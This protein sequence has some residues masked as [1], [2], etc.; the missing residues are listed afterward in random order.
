[1]RK[2]LSAVA[3]A[4]VVVAGCGSPGANNVAACNKF[5]AALKCGSFDYTANYMCSSYENTTCDI[6]AYFD[7]LTPKYSCV[8]GGFDSAKYATIA[9]CTSKAT[10]K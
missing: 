3:L 2:I 6:S 10:C 5:A 8:D 9:D 7:C 4:G 1:M